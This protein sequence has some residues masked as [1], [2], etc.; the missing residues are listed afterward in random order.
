MIHLLLC[1]TSHPV[2]SLS[3]VTY[4]RSTTLL[5]KCPGPMTWVNNFRGFLI[6]VNIIFDLNMST[7]PLS[8]IKDKG[9]FVIKS[10]WKWPRLIDW[11]LKLI[12]DPRWLMIQVNWWLRSIDDSSKLM[13][14][15]NWCLKNKSSLLEQ[16]FRSFQIF[17]NT[18][19]WTEHS[20]GLSQ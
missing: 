5:S 7:R 9:Q 15:V 8:L 6:Q 4:V 20:F 18:Y 2:C 1:H 16:M 13:A 14:Q 19:P 11:W 17:Q 12:D 3:T 10:C